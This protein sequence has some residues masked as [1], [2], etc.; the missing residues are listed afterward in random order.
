MLAD[1]PAAPPELPP[2]GALLSFSIAAMIDLDLDARRDLLAS[3]S[4]SGRLRQLEALLQPALP[5][6][7]HRAEVHERAKTNGRGSHL[8]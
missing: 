5:K 2:E 4:A 3:R 6:L 7:A 8:P 1:A